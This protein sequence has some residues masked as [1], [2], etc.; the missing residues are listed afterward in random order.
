MLESLATQHNYDL[1]G[2]EYNNAFLIPHEINP[3]PTLSAAEAFRKGFIERTDRAQKFPWNSSMESIYT[4]SAA[5]SEA[6]LREK[7]QGLEGQYIL[8]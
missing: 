2:L 5:E 7:F 1:V 8:E 3:V 6:F 4:M